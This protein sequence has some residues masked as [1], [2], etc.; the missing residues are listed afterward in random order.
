MALFPRYGR[1]KKVNLTDP[2]P[3]SGGVLGVALAKQRVSGGARQPAQGIDLPEWRPT[4]RPQPAQNEYVGPVP[5]GPEPAAPGKK[6]GMSDRTRSMLSA[7]LQGAAAGIQADVG[8]ARPG[9]GFAQGI[10]KGLVGAGAMA[11]AREAAAGAQEQERLSL[12]GKM[13]LLEARRETPEQAGAKAGAKAKAEQP[14]K[15]EL[16][17]QTGEV[18]E[19][20]AKLV[21]DNSAG[22][23][24]WQAVQMN[25]MVQARVDARFKTAYNFNPSKDELQQMVTEVKVQMRSGTDIIAEPD[26]P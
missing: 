15:L 26:L 14:Y 11:R 19:R 21:K 13:A 23:T 8:P 18:R 5:L 3:G 25:N 9:G 1:P 7:A 17:R 22:L 2:L 4:L 20:I 6:S 12:A 10:L 24:A 16:Q